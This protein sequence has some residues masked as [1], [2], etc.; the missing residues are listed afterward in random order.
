MFGLFKPQCPLQTDEKAWTE[1]RMKWFADQFGLDTMRSA[2][3]ILPSH[4]NLTEPFRGTDEETERLLDWLCSVLQIDRK[5]ITLEIVS[6]DESAKYQPEKGQTGK[7]VLG[8]S[9]LQNGQIFLARVMF[10]LAIHKLL[11]QNLLAP[12]RF[13]FVITAELLPLFFG[14]GIFG[15]NAVLSE[16]IIPSSLRMDGNF[17]SS[18]EITKH[19]DLPARI[20][21]YAFSH[22]AWHRIESNPEWKN[23]LRKDA[24]ESYNQGLKFLTKTED[25]IFLDDGLELSRRSLDYWMDEL[26]AGFISSQYIALWH[27]QEL[28]KDSNDPKLAEAVIAKFNSKDFHI[29][30]NA[31]HTLQIIS[32]E[33]DSQKE[34]L[35]IALSDPSARV[36]SRAITALSHAQE[37]AEDVI[38]AITDY[39]ED[40]DSSV[41]EAAAQSLATFESQAFDSCEKIMN[42]LREAIYNCE[43]NAQVVYLTALQKIDENWNDQLQTMIDRLGDTEVQ[44]QIESLLEEMNGEESL[45]LNESAQ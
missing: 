3:M 26:N 4:P 43:F 22:L 35:I 1:F 44:T 13:D 38:P 23:H 10:H 12:D 20:F 40:P 21:G 27:I 2:E 11:H 45:S 6:D 7:I 17:L 39:L 31:V 5:E 8:I 25:T 33:T 42:C 30:Q 34:P 41:R 16:E 19:S 28:A 36:R 9:L 15:A 29:R 14:L 32:G 24:V 37:S 18:L